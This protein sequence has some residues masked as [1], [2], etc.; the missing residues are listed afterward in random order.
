MENVRLYVFKEYLPVSQ[1]TY[2]LQA[3]HNLDALTEPGY[4]NRVFWPRLS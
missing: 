4:V 3:F 2:E 1:S